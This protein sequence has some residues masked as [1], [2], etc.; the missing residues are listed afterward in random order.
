MSIH[1]DDVFEFGDEFNQPDSIIYLSERDQ[2]ILL[3][4]LVKLLKPSE[5][6]NIYKEIDRISRT[7]GRLNYSVT[8][9]FCYTLLDENNLEDLLEPICEE[10]DCLSQNIDS[11]LRGI[12]AHESDALDDESKQRISRSLLRLYDH[13]QLALVQHR[14]IRTPSGWLKLQVKDVESRVD[15]LDNTQKDLRDMQ[16]KALEALDSAERSMTN[17]IIGI[18][19]IFT[20]LS[21]VLFGGI[22]ALS[23]VTQLFTEPLFKIISMGAI[24][25]IG[26]FNLLLVFAHFIN[27]IIGRNEAASAKSPGAGTYK[28][29]KG[30]WRQNWIFFVVN[31]SLLLL[32][33]ISSSLYFLL[34]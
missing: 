27:R 1:I 28:P 8:T 11:L 26:M 4:Q 6:E 34:K 21:F 22:S 25:G 24:W 23:T 30:F 33:L 14:Q 12:D 20:A 13:V 15:D 10:I 7:Y 17:Q 5:F 31:G 3:K 16:G 29:I 32:L 2:N 19:A 18:V 9:Q